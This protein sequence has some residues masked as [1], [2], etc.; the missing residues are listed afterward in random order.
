M[1]KKNK[2]IITTF[3][4]IRKKQIKAEKELTKQ[5][6]EKNL[7]EITEQHSEVIWKFLDDPEDNLA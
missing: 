3:N 6:K 7:N 5:L 4:S 2:K 1:T